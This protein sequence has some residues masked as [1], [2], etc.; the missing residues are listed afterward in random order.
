MLKPCLQFLHQMD[1]C[2]YFYAFLVR[3]TAGASESVGEKVLDWNLLIAQSSYWSE[4]AVTPR[5]TS[6][7]YF[8]SH[9]TMHGQEDYKQQWR[10]VLVLMTLMGLFS[11]KMY[12]CCNTT[13]ISKD[14]W[15]C[16]TVLAPR[17]RHHCRLGRSYS[18]LCSRTSYT[19]MCSA[20]GPDI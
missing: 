18:L 14:V 19:H 8:F 3:V 9:I 7:N 1:T 13:A 12:I 11:I 16:V 20:L 10:A 4:N 6:P 5:L 17:Y 15:L 2:C